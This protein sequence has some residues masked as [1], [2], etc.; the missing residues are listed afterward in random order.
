MRHDVNASRREC[1]GRFCKVKISRVQINY[2]YP[3]SINLFNLLSSQY[4]CIS[5]F[6]FLLFNIVFYGSYAIFKPHFSFAYVKSVKK[7]QKN[8][9]K[10][11]KVSKTCPKSVKKRLKSVQKCPKSVQKASKSVQNAAKSVKKASNCI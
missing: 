11:S 8:V 10:R 7:C 2:M 6:V 4:H 3:F 1:V 5:L 9:K